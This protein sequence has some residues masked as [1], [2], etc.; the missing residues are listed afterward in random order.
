MSTP[1]PILIHAYSGPLGGSE[2]ILLDLLA[3]LDRAAVLAC[4]AG[5]LADAAASID[6]PVVRLPQRPLEAR[7]TVA[8]LGA[9]AHLLA[10]GR[11]IRKL[12]EDLDPSLVISWGMRSAI[13]STSAW[14]ELVVTRGRSRRPPIVAEHVD[15]LPE[16]AQGRLA[17]RALLACDRVVCLSEAIARDLDP[18][19]HSTGRISVV[20]PGVDRATSPKPPAPQQPTALM[21]AAIEPWKGQ[22]V[23]LEAVA[24]VP[25]I[26]LVVAG[27]PLSER[28]ER[29]ALQLKERASDPDLE[30]RVDFPGTVD[31][32]E[33]LAAA[34]L[35]LHCAPAEPFGRAMADAL[36]AGRPVV[37]PDAAGAREI[38]T[39]DC[40]RLVPARDA[41]AC[42]E[43]LEEIC[44]SPSLANQLG[45]AGFRR[46]LD[47]FDQDRQAE[48]WRRA[49]LSLAPEPRRALP[50]GTAQPADRIGVGN[51]PAVTT[52]SD[53]SLV[54]VIHDSAPDLSRL[55]ASVA[56]HL[57]G[58]EVI[59][60]DSGSS[61]AGPAVAAMWHGGAKLITLSSNEGFGAGCVA[62]IELASRQ[63]GVLINPDVELVDS[64][65][66]DLG[67]LL[68][69][70]GAPDRLLSPVL[71]HPDGRRQDAV[72][73]APGTA[74]ELLRALVPASALP[75]PLNRI[76][77]PHRARSPIPVGWAVGA[78][79]IGRTT[80]L[81]SLGPFDPSVQL[82][83][84]DLDLCLRAA[85]CGIETWY[86]PEARVL[87]REAHSTS[88][89]F[90][91]E[92]SELLAERRRT[93]VGQRLVASGLR[94]NCARPEAPAAPA[95][96]R[97]RE[98][99]R[100][101]P[102][103]STVAWAELGRDPAGV[104]GVHVA[105]GSGGVVQYTAPAFRSA[106][107][108]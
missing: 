106:A 76:A 70:P 22:D 92:P 104:V 100:S 53:L 107:K 85:E 16:G 42:S 26:R 44:S 50:A 90:G 63:I 65:L 40:G 21:L 79:L 88:R 39:P 49:A 96:G 52:G 72:H 98:V 11:E 36:G 19:W 33:A 59:V 68:T 86:H 10:H 77:E 27:S 89:I 17:R 91:G 81:H 57:P 8:V 7:G 60:V 1:R 38:V 69:D 45:E 31:P 56:R 55:L 80:T 51:A 95:S 75:A 48:R 29:F 15:L 2:R 47:A 103:L 82:Y 93:V 67:A 14:G 74:P 3:R 28:G 32:H 84:E 30:G 105:S 6:L 94:D 108:T 87:H 18:T 46:A 5:P 4:P 71:L 97:L 54:T 35:L 13:A 23:A 24:M 101:K 34:T 78:C 62:G 9:G 12:A 41:A 61:D 43:A 73:P 20:H 64:S 37:A 102:E 25:G 99:R 83:A 66:A 58:A